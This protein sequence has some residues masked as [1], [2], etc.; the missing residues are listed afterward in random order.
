MI[1]II[2]DILGFVFGVTGA[3]MV[4]QLNRMGFILFILGSTSHGVLGLLQG[5]YGL[6]TTCLTFIAIDIYYYRKW[7]KN[8]QNKTFH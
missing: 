3:L 6:L 4:G 2:L 7:G 5:N 8:E 1:L